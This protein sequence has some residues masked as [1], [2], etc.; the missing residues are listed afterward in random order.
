MGGGLG[1]E[2]QT[3]LARSLFHPF[4]RANPSS[5]PPTEAR[6]GQPGSRRD[7]PTHCPSTMIP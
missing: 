3:G 1:D 6:S 5:L 7:L 2:G 4:R